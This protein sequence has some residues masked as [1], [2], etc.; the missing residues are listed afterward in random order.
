MCDAFTRR[1][2]CSVT[3]S[4]PSSLSWTGCGRKRRRRGR[5]RPNPRVIGR[6]RTRE[7]AARC[8]PDRT[9]EVTRTVASGVRSRCGGGQIASHR[10]RRVR[11]RSARRDAGWRR[12]WRADPAPCSLTARRPRYGSCGPAET[13]L[14]RDVSASRWAL[15]R[16]DRLSQRR[17][18]G[19]DR[20]RRG[21]RYPV[22]E[23]GAHAA[24]HPARDGPPRC[25]T[26][27][28]PGRGAAHL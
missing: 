20:R 5:L 7:R 17:H 1:V 14:R 11:G 26:S 8:R 18:A 4:S 28:R 23:R 15:A 3:A 9:A 6:L 25:Q 13:H 16:T 12:S 10:S 22:H 27:M 2:C 19:T 21:G 24:G